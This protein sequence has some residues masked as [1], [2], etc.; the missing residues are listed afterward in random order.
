MTFNVTSVFA[1]TKNLI[2]DGIIRLSSIT[3][4]IQKPE[5]V[6]TKYIQRALIGSFEM[7]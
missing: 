6:Y 5:I 7:V 1:S 2:G 4:Y 3:K